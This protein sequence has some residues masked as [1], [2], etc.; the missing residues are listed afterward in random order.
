MVALGTDRAISAGIGEQAYLTRS[1]R[2]ALQGQG[3]EGQG[4]SGFD[5]ARVFVAQGVQAGGRERL[6]LAPGC[7][8]ADK[9][10]V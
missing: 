3:F 10:K 9:P 6:R 4:A 7:A 2:V 8:S 5:G 1:L